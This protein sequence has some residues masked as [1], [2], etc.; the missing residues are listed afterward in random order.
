MNAELRRISTALKEL[1]IL[2]NKLLTAM[3]QLKLNQ[4]NEENS[5]LEGWVFMDQ[6]KEILGISSSTVYRYIENGSLRAS[7]VGSRYLFK[8][9]DI[10]TLLE[11]NYRRFEEG[12]FDDE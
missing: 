5:D 12:D 6:V 8:V 3:S 4:S 2:N 11:R 1:T 9:E 10:N 7:K